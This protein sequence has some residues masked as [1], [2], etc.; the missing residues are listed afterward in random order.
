M[1]IVENMKVDDEDGCGTDDV[2]KMKKNS[3]HFHYFRGLKLCHL[4]LVNTC[5]VV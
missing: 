4:L 5:V 3:V 2:L 1:T